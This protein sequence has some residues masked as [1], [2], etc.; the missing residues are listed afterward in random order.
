MACPKLNNFYMKRTYAQDSWEPES[1][2][3]ALSLLPFSGHKNSMATGTIKRFK[4]KNKKTTR[5]GNHNFK[6]IS[7]TTKRQMYFGNFLMNLICDLE[8][9]EI[10]Q[11]YPLAWWLLISYFLWTMSQKRH[12]SQWGGGV[13]PNSSSSFKLENTIWIYILSLQIHRR[14]LEHKA[15]VFTIKPIHPMYAITRWCVAWASNINH[16]LF[17]FLL[18]FMSLSF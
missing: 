10:N 12:C 11:C 15:S 3:L 4:N 14:S 7:R 2:P 6:F 13:F 9:E 18:T 1:M 17:M 8:S 16:T 5:L